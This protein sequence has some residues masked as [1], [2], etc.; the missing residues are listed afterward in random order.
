Y[1]Q[2]HKVDEVL[3]FDDRSVDGTAEF[4]KK[5]IQVHHIDNWTVTINNDQKGVFHNFIN[6]IKC[7]TGDIIFLAD[8]DDVWSKNK[9]EKMLDIFAL[10]PFVLSLTS[11]FS[12]FREERSLSAHVVHPHRK[13]NDLKRI[14]LHDF[15]VFPYYLG[16]SM[17][18]SKKLVNEV[19]QRE[20]FLMA[21][22]IKE[23]ITHDILINFLACMEDGFYHV[24]QVLTRRRSY[25]TSVSNLKFKN[26]L[27]NFGGNQKQYRIA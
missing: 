4:C 20:E 8:Q 27:F 19:I 12:R 2:S 25:G 21:I 26:E 11:T 9:V 15:L 16:M 5:Y 3:I 7:S 1:N 24:D 18:I 23:E 22:D 13:K 6:A 17:A 14:G 10:N